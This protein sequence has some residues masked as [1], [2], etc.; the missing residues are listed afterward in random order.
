MKDGML[1]TL[2]SDIVSA[3]VSKNSVAVNDLP[4]LIRSVYQAM[5]NTGQPSPV[6][7]EKCEPAISIRASVK[8]DA[9]A[10][11]E[12]GFKAKMLKRHLVTHHGLTPQDYRA[13]WGLSSDH[14]L[15]APDYAATRSR[16]AKSFGLGRKL[17]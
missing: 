1:I 9:V 12:C 7:Q 11:I 8:A 16:I 5:V 13:R 17:G 6:V 15:V 4:T 10:C 2:T 14:P 3:H